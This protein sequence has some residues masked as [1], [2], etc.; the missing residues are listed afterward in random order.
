MVVRVVVLSPD[1]HAHGF[2]SRP[3]EREEITI[4]EIKSEKTGKV[5]E[6]KEREKE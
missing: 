4:T 1:S 6:G 5:R 2:L 3:E